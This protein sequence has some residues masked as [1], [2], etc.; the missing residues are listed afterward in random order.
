MGVK[1]NPGT[2][3]VGAAVAWPDTEVPG[4]L[5]PRLNS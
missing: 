3:D 1:P 2:A 5:S 4:Q